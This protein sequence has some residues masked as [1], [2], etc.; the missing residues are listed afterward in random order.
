MLKFVDEIRVAIELI[1][2]LSSLWWALRTIGTSS[3][4]KD[5]IFR[6]EDDVHDHVIAL[7]NS[8]RKANEACLKVKERI[9]P[10]QMSLINQL[11]TQVYEME[12]SKDISEL[13]AKV[14][15]YQEVQQFYKDNPTSRYFRSAD[16]VPMD[17]A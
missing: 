3:T 8:I 15:L 11:Q 4:L 2:T 17:D 5:D 6:E 10:Q 14:K 13:A 1:L 16:W 12:Q 7:Q 9:I